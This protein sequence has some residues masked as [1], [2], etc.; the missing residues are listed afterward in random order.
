MSGMLTTKILCSACVVLDQQQNVPEFPWTLQL[1]V[2]SLGLLHAIDNAWPHILSGTACWG[3]LRSLAAL[4]VAQSCFVLYQESV[5]ASCLM[6]ALVWWG[7]SLLNRV[8][9]L[10]HRRVPP[11]EMEDLEHLVMLATVASR[12]GVM[13]WWTPGLMEGGAAA[14][15]CAVARA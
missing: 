7:I 3:L 6:M 8:Q 14:D 1:Y 13:A 5:E 15:A 11:R 9:W 2:A 12:D 4:L 10:T